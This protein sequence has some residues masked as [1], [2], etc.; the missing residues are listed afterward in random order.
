MTSLVRPLKWN[1]MPDGCYG[2]PV[3]GGSLLYIIR[4]TESGWCN[5]FGQFY[6]D[7]HSTQ[8]DAEQHCQAHFDAMIKPHLFL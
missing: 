2:S 4:K 7:L 1:K 6:M 3:M 5:Y 8:E